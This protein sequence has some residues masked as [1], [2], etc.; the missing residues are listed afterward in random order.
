MSTFVFV[1]ILFIIASSHVTQ[2]VKVSK[3]YIVLTFLWFI[4]ILM[5]WCILFIFFNRWL[6]FVCFFFLI[7]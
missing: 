7:K 5:F 3:F 6:I 1:F 4:I 2:E